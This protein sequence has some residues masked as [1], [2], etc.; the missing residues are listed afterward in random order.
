MPR[1]SVITPAYNARRWI[2]GAIASVQRQTYS[3]WELV[4]CDD[5]STDATPEL[6]ANMAAKD[7]RIRLVRANHGGIVPSLNTAIAASTGDLIARMD[8]DDLCH[9]F[10]LQRQVEML[11]A[12]PDLWMAS[13]LV[14][15]FPRRE[16]PEGMQ[17]YE[18]W[19]NS[20]VSH[21]EIIRDF[22][23]ESPFAHPSVTMRRASLDAVRGYHDPG[24]AEDYDLW[25]RM[26]LAGARFAKVPEVLFYWR[27]HDQ[28]L[29]RTEEEYSMR[30][31]RALKIHYLRL[32][33]LKGADAVQIWSAGHS[34]RN[35]ARDL[36][37]AGLRILRFID[38]D[39]QKIGTS[40]R[41]AP[42]VAV[43][44]LPPHRGEPLLVCLGVR[45]VRAQIREALASMSFV[46]WRDFVCV[47]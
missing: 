3:D 28:R 35:W 6:V 1:V 22:F 34:G 20:I 33:Y 13:C 21:E 2:Y 9:P 15:C 40:V 37:R 19:L 26:R 18:E 17:R 41:G 25:M 44:D 4:V 14:R 38:I 47:A 27:D 12:Q 30:V 5:G 32:D 11:D 31:F 8:A 23:V 43:E 7:S 39:P 42:V 16:V 45:G 46:E 24:W 10:R 36:Q 29:T